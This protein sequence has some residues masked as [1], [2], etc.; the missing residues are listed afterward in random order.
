M[1]IIQLDAIAAEKELPELIALLI[2][3]VE[4]GA[5]IGFVN[6]VENTEVEV[7]W[8]KRL[9]AIEGGDCILLAVYIDDE[10]AGSAQ[11]GLESRKNGNHRAEVQKVMVH[12]KFRRRGIGRELMQALEEKAHAH[13]RTTLVLDTI[14]GAPSNDLYLKMGFI[15]AGTIPEYARSPDGSTLESTELYYKLLK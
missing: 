9:A 7:Y 6:P 13:Q 14:S 15:H 8:R 1:N 12:T 2:D 10:L 4:N 5:S 3:S 11:L